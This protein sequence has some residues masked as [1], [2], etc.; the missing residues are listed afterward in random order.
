MS[1]GTG[2]RVE[3]QRQSGGQGRRPLAGLRVI[4]LSSLLAG[5]MAASV[6]GDFGADVIKVERPGIGDEVRRWGM[7]KDGSSL[8]WHLLG[9]G[10]RSL[11][12]D[13]HY[14]E[15][16]ELLRR[17]VADANVL[18]ESFRPGTLERW[19]LGWDELHARN[20]G[21]VLVRVSGFGQTGPART[22]PGFGTVAEAMSGFAHL[23]GSPDGPPTLP[24]FGLAD[25][26]AA[27]SAVS[28]VMFALWERDVGGSGEGQVVDVSLYEP[29][30]QVVGA[31]LAAAGACGAAPTRTGSRSPF[32]APRNVY[33]TA[34]GRWI[35]ISAATQSVAERLFA[36]MGRRDLLD[37]PRYATNAAR[38]AH[39]E[40]LDGLVE[41]WTSARDR[42]EV[43]AVLDAAEVAA[44]P[45]NTITDL[46]ADRHLAERGSITGL[47]DPDLRVPIPQVPFRLSRT[48]G[49]VA[50]APPAV[51]EH[52]DEVLEQLVG[53]TADEVAALRARSIV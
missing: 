25:T 18:I 29:L 5:P 17:L 33:P 8:H 21:L 12:L 42:A 28:A 34:D 20:A 41:A 37:D 51:G 35:A 44:G 45:V 22:R 38:V 2:D 36:A 40:E 3:R 13:L 1:D 6:L 7:A 24:P 30:M 9:H 15:G 50:G 31:Q 39:V 14:D 48:P 53:L 46:L 19:G 27:M 26:M 47:D 16:R 4:D 10:K 11:T 43:L 32:A 23:N 52:T 49:A